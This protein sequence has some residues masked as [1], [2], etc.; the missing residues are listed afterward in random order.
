MLVRDAY[1]RLLQGDLRET[2]HNIG[3]VPL[4]H[5][6]G[7]YQLSQRWS[8]RGDLDGS[9]APQGRA[10]DAAI[11]AHYQSPIGWH[12][13]FGLRS[14]EGG[15]DNDEVYSFGWWYQMFGRMGWSF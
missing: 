6:A 10:V 4:L 3:A 8:L 5:L 7:R 1:V 2:E 14:L 15:A 9:W 13:G 12:V 11:A